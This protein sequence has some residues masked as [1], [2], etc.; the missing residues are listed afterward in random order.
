MKLEQA[1]VLAGGKGTTF[2]LYF[3]HPSQ[4]EKSKSMLPLRGKPLLEH[5]ITSLKAGGITDI[6]VAVCYGKDSIRE[7]FKNGSELGVSLRYLEDEGTGHVRALRMFEPY[8][9]DL[10]VTCYGDHY[11]SEEFARRCL[12]NHEHRGVSVT[13]Y[14]STRLWPNAIMRVDKQNKIRD[15]I[16]WNLGECG[17]FRDN[18]P[19]VSNRLFGHRRFLKYGHPVSKNAHVFSKQVFDL[20]NLDVDFISSVLWQLSLKNQAY[21]IRHEEMEIHIHNMLSYLFALKLLDRDS[22]ERFA[23]ELRPDRVKTIEHDLQ[24]EVDGEGKYSWEN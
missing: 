2:N 10:F 9:D 1:I 16:S 7:Y 23:S 11:F 22:Y 14:R 24:V 20:V 13:Y 18:E 3:S 15:I 8:A 4:L 12:R 21:A 17:P 19:H 6:T 5:I